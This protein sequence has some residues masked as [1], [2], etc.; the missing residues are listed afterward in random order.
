MKSLKSD[1]YSRS[2]MRSRSSYEVPSMKVT[3]YLFLF[4]KTKSIWEWPKFLT[5]NALHSSK[6]V[7]ILA[8]CYPV[9]VLL[10]NSA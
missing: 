5:K 2:T 7:S 1:A 9:T 8:I 4:M 10:K 3:A 6:K